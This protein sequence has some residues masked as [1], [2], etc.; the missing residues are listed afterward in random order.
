VIYRD[1]LIKMQSVYQSNPNLGDPSLIEGQLRESIQRL[2]KLQQEMQKYQ[3]YLNEM[4]SPQSLQSSGYG[5]TNGSRTS[6]NR[7]SGSDESLSR[8]ASDL[9]QNNHKP[10]A[11]STPLPSHGYVV[12]ISFMMSSTVLLIK[13]FDRSSNSP[14]SGIS[15]SH[16]SLPDSDFEPIDNADGDYEDPLPV[17]GTCEALYSFE[18]NGLSHT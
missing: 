15:T 5:S 6:Q 4:D 8:S 18:G 11:P 2:Q 1:G 9:S 10:S 12:N 7:S 3:S 17:L 16:T 14:E 13:P